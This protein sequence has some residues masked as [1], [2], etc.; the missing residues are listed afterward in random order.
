MPPFPPSS[1]TLT[2]SPL[3]APSPPA[4]RLT[5]SFFLTSR[6]PSHPDSKPQPTLFPP[7]SPFTPAWASGGDSLYCTSND[8]GLNNVH[9]IIGYLF[10]PLFHFSLFLWRFIITIMMMI[11]RM[12]LKMRMKMTMRIR[13]RKWLVVVV[14]TI[15][16]NIIIITVALMVI[17]RYI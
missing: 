4:S 5:C 11:M 7:L 13:M 8:A 14:E 16:I 6:K 1:L 2:P 10:F 3:S 12:R 15:R 9:K 17:D